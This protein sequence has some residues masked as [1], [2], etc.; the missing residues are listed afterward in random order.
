MPRVDLL[1]RLLFRLDQGAG[2]GVR[3]PLHPT[4]ILVGG[5][6]E[7]LAALEKQLEELNEEELLREQVAATQRKVDAML[8]KRLFN[9]RIRGAHESTL[10]G[11]VD[12]GVAENNLLNLSR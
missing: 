11:N 10:L 1:A 3:P 12:L 9:V 7:Q 6:R 2:F 4:S 5:L 8:A